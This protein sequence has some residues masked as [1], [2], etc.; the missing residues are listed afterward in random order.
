MNKEASAQAQMEFNLSVL[1]RMD[2][3]IISVLLEERLERIK[4][5]NV[6]KIKNKEKIDN[7]KKQNNFALMI[8]KKCGYLSIVELFENIELRDNVNDK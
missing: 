6:D 8:V 3:N 2:K 7:I 5:Y 4:A 1:Q